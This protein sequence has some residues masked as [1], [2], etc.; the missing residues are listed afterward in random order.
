MSTPSQI[1][2]DYQTE[3]SG[4]FERL[5][6]KISEMTDELNTLRTT[7]QTVLGGLV[8]VKQLLA[9]FAEQIPDPISPDTSNGTT[10]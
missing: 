8:A 6:R 3:I 2:T 10:V 1:L 9:R 5:D 4:E 7:R